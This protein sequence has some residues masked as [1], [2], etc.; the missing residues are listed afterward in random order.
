MI[1]KSLSNEYEILNS[2][3]A[4]KCFNYTVPIVTNGRFILAP[5]AKDFLYSIFSK[6]GPNINIENI[7]Y[8]CMDGYLHRDHALSANYQFA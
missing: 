5:S 2:Q 3:C 8:T 7:S 1:L 6:V 4:S